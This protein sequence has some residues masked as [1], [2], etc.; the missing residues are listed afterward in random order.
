MRTLSCPGRRVRFSRA[1]GLAVVLSLFGLGSSVVRA[2]DNDGAGWDSPYIDQPGDPGPQDGPGTHKHHKH[3]NLAIAIEV[4]NNNNLAEL[5][6]G[7]GDFASIGIY[8]NH[9]NIDLIQPGSDQFADVMFLGINGLNLPL[10]QTGPAPLTFLMTP[11]ALI[12]PN[13]IIGPDVI[14]ERGPDGWI[15]KRR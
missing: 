10:V 11:N 2:E 8:G 4:G 6:G 15:I 14:A 13:L 1:V 9:D 12:T 7:H 5:Q 3:G